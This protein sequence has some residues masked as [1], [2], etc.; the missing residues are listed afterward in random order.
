[1]TGT[2]RTLCLLDAHGA[3]LAVGGIAGPLTWQALAGRAGGSIAC[4]LRP[5]GK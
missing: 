4:G 3:K 2:V 5:P 1:M